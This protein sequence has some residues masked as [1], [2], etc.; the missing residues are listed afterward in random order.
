[1]ATSR[2]ARAG[3]MAAAQTNT[4]LQTFSKRRGV[5][6]L[7]SKIKAEAP[8][9]LESPARLKT[10][11][12]RRCL[13]PGGNPLW[14]APEV[15][16]EGFG[17]A[18]DVLPQQ[19]APT[20][21]RTQGQNLVNF[22]QQSLLRILLVHYPLSPLVS[23]G[24]FGEL[25]TSNVGATV[26]VGHRRNPLLRCLLPLREHRSKALPRSRV[27]SSAG[28]TEAVPRQRESLP[29]KGGTQPALTRCSSLQSH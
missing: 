25:V 3:K 6:V 16:S 29:E 10:K 2:P 22:Y 15:L 27:G 14:L 12:S 8:C 13:S 20:L 24:D 19:L 5:I 17:P 28:A 11:R 4:F 26:G 21:V 7:R 9:I 18:A 1:M 23:Y